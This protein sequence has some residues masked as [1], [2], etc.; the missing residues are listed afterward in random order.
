[1]NTITSTALGLTGCFLVIAGILGMAV[2]TSSIP[3]ALSIIL[4]VVGI[5][6]LIVSTCGIVSTVYKENKDE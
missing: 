3:I 5:F 6:D 1:M 4:S 2:P